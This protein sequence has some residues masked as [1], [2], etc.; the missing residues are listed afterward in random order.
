M[1]RNSPY[2]HPISVVTVIS[3]AIAFCIALLVPRTSAAD[4]PISQLQ[5][6]AEKG[7]VPREIELAAAYF[8]GRGVPPD[9]RMAAY[10]YEKAAQSGDPAAQNEIGF[11]Y[12]TGVGVPADPARAIHWYMLS[13]SSGLVKAKVNLGVVYFWG[14]GVP[15]D[16]PLARQLFREAANKGSGIAST[17]LG[18]MYYFGT[19]VSQDRAAAESWYIKGVKLHDPVA[20]YNLAS[21]FRGKDDHRSDLPK[22]AVLLRESVAGG[23]VPAMHLLGFL[24]VNHPDLAKSPQEARS[25][26]ETASSAGS[27]KSSALLGI[28]ARDGINMAADHEA[29]YYRFQ[30]AI[31]QGGEEA[32]R[33]LANDLKALSAT[34]TNEQ[35]ETIASNADAWFQQHRLALNFIYKDAENSIRFPASARAVAEGEAH[36]G[37]LIP[38]P[39][40]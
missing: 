19:G 23:Y 18:D 22:A 27:W 3:V 32:K 15:M 4:I 26:L 2:R 30:I 13:A 5:A 33:L 17:Y 20:A 14:I 35:D 16:R 7:L 39:P 37:Q 38:P 10:W 36:G 9:M 8:S 12:Q 40:S 29:A 1:V 28:L 24:L 11:L 21:V 25:L 6:D 34:L 31:L